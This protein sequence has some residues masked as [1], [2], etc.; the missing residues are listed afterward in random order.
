MSHLEVLAAAERHGIGVVAFTDHDTLPDVATMT[1]LR[2]YD[3]PVEWTVGVELSSFVP[4]AAG[5]P[6]RGA[7]HI[8]GLFVDASDSDLRAFCAEAEHNRMKRMQTYVKHLQSLGFTVTEADVLSQASSTNIVSPHMVKALGL[9]SE[10]RAVME[11]I[12][13]E[14]EAAA[15]HDVKLAAKLAQTLKDGDNQWPYTLFMSR[16]SF[17]SAPDTGKGQLR[18]YEATVKLIRDAGGLAVAAHWYLEPDKMTAADLEAVIQAGGL[19]GIESEV[20]NVINNRDL[21]EGARVSRELVGRYDLIETVGSDSHTE[22]DL[23][24]F[25]MSPVAQHSIGQTARIV[26]KMKPQLEWSNLRSG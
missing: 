24:A 11:R 17:R 18:S 16:G 21:S 1:G 19:D 7:V 25:A 15:A 12:R 4:E 10:N 9:H 14:F 20:E 13:A 3:G 6:E 5:G 2:A 26:E 8:L 23:A 22:A